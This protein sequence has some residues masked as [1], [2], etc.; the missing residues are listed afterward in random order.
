MDERPSEVVN[1]LDDLRQRGIAKL[2]NKHFTATTKQLA[3]EKAQADAALADLEKRR[4]STSK[5]EPSKGGELSPFDALYVELQQKRAE[6]RRKEKETLLLYQR[7]VHKF[8]TTGK[9]AAPTM[10]DIISP[11]PPSPSDSTATA[12]EAPPPPS[13]V[14]PPVPMRTLNEHS[15]DAGEE[16]EIAK[17]T[18]PSVG[19][20]PAEQRRPDPPE[21][22]HKIPSPRNEEQ[23]E[24]EEQPPEIKT[25]NS[26]EPPGELQVPSSA[27]GS[28]FFPAATPTMDDSDTDDRSTISGLTSVNSATTRK[29]MDELENEFETFIKTET[30]QIRKDLVVD[31]DESKTSFSESLMEKTMAT[32]ATVG[33]EQQKV[34]VKAEAMVAQMQQI[35]RDFQQGDA[36][37]GASSA[38]PLLDPEDA[39]KT[40]KHD[41]SSKSS[42]YP[43]KYETSNP[44]EEWMVH[45]DETYQREYY[46]EKQSGKTQ[47]ETPSSD[48]T[49]AQQEDPFSH[50]DVMPDDRA[51]TFKR[52]TSR[53]NIYRKKIRKQRRRR[54]AA[55]TLAGVL[56][57]MVV[58]HWK[59]NYADQSFLDATSSM[60]QDAFTRIE[61][62]VTDRKARED[63]EAF[64]AEQL[65]LKKEA[66]RKA[67]EEESERKRQAKIAADL[68]AKEEARQKELERKQQ[69]EERK[70]KEAQ[71]RKELEEIE[72]ESRSWKCKLPLATKRNP[73]C[74]R[75]STPWDVKI[76]ANNVGLSQYMIE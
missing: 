48:Q 20:E 66:E 1:E 9:V 52:R 32:S 71:R 45:W 59:R 69:E 55:L 22:P 47:W 60:V 65:R 18:A 57:G 39:N 37:A 41:K 61:Y 19:A 42:Q 68:K 29:V 17:D 63:E 8:G 5:F 4:A 7:Y 12:A 3:K 74:Q 31:L 38:S 2:L 16:I 49:H 14:P 46:F 67:R 72:R 75:E 44:D 53:R 6:C 23:A 51:A 15:V 35:L 27:K 50:A 64:K 24:E 43:K 25:N 70:A 33:E 26:Q 76:D 28:E 10:S 40:A 34:A 56:V 30:E 62:A 13:P 58:I 54:I 73:H 11:I 21:S 36:G